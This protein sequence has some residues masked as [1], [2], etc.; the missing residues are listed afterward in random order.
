MSSYLHIEHQLGFSSSVT[1]RAK[2][3]YERLV[4]DHGVIVDLYKADNGLFKANVFVTH[5]WE[6]N[7]K[8]SPCTKNIAIPYHFFGSKI[9]NLK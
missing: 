8:I 6:Q 1:L 3:S 7:L 4:L 2:Q 9:T 5:I